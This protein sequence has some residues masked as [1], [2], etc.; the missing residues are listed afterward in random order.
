MKLPLSICKDT[1]LFLQ[2]MMQMRNI[3]CRN[4]AILVEIYYLWRRNT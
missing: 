1:N 4:I 2:H 3:L